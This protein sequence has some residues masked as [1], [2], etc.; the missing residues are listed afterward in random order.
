[1]GKKLVVVESPTKA[2]TI[3]GI[4][5]REYRVMAT[6]GHIRDLPRRRMGVDIEAGF[7]P[8]YVIAPRKRKTV[9]RLKEATAAADSLFLAT[10][11]DREGEAIAWHVIQAVGRGMR[12]RRV[13]RAV[14][15]EL[16]AHAVRAALAN[17]RQLDQNLVDAQQARRVLDRLV[18]Y[19]ISPLLWR[20]FRG[21]KGLSAGRVQ[22]AALR[23]VVER[24]REIEAF[25]PE[26]Y[27]T[28]D[29]ELHPPGAPDALFLA[30]LIK[31]G[32]DQVALDDEVGARE[33]MADLEGVAYRVADV[34]RER[35]RRLP[36]PPY[37]TGS[38]QRDAA[39]S[40]RWSPKRTM[41]VAQE[42]FEGVSLPDEGRVGLI[43]YMR[44][45][46]PHVA[47]EAQREARAVIAD[48]FGEQALPD[49]PPTYS[50]QMRNTQEAH[51]AIRPTSPARLPKRAAPHLTPEQATL[52][53][54]I[55]RRFIASQMRPAFYDVTTVD[56]EARGRSGT[57]YLFRATGRKTLE[58][59]FLH[60]YGDPG[61]DSL[62]P[63]LA[64]GDPLVCRRLIPKQRLTRPPPRYTEGSLI[65]ELQ[66]L[67]IGRPS[68]YASIIDTIQK[69]GYV[70]RRR[71]ALIS[72][73]LG[74]QVCDYLIE[75]F[76][77]I[78]DLKF[79]ARMEARL[80]D[81]ASGRVGW[82]EVVRE[83]Y[84]LLSASLPQ[85]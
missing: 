31:V 10:D 58:R 40:L 7:K 50:A 71:R 27:W 69:R 67:G 52:Y 13:Q 65:K 56:V 16:T 78:F 81:V 63:P 26:E 47:P 14:F 54:L 70:C 74:R 76:P 43:T 18:G 80:D 51:E 22:T 83:F 46:S 34:R 49:E 42:L 72:T 55:W 61:Q 35:Q 1:M 6:R 17:P 5:G 33:V 73:A 28:L 41:K 64:A 85:D 77:A 11:P 12:G 32:D 44:T 68:T 62:L 8:R 84:N 2:R 21:H 25:V 59:G 66:R 48:L 3:G 36:P 29:A 9:Q 37:T 30:R 19:L 23:L 82:Q 79:T 75:Q 4:L 57:R 24:D 38:M 39:S 45:D 53:R 15:H 60:V 20:L